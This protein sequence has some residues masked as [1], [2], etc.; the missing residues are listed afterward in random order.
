MDRRT[1]FRVSGAGAA[2]AVS[3]VAAIGCQRPP[4]PPS[5]F[6][7]Y[8]VSN[9]GDDQNSGTGQATPWRTIERVN[10]ALREGAM[11]DGA[12]VLFQRGG[13][14][15]GEIVARTDE[16][17]AI[18]E[19]RVLLSGYGDGPRPTI[20]AYK[21]L[22]SAEAW[23]EVQPD[24]WTV[25]LSDR[26]SYSGNIA[27]GDANVG[28][29]RVDGQIFGA[30]WSRVGELSE[31]W[32]FYNDD[33]NL[34]VRSAGAPSTLATDL[35]AAVNGILISGYSGLSVI[36]LELVGCGGH[37]Y[38]QTAASGTEVSDCLIH[39][40]G[41][42][43]LHAGDPTRY[44][45]GIELWM[46]SKDAV[47]ADN[48]IFDVYD[49]ATTVQ[50]WQE[51]DARLSITNCAFR[52]NLIWNCTQAFEFWAQGSQSRP[53]TGLVDCSFTDNVCVNAGRSWGYAARKDTKH[54]GNFVM[55]HSQDLSMGVSITGNIFFEAL[56][57][58]VFVSTNDYRFRPGIVFDH[59]VIA[60]R[61]NT[62]IQAELPFTIEQSAEW[63]TSTGQDRHSTWM[64]VPPS[65]ASPAD[66]LQYVRDNADVLRARR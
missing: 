58:Y 13:V 51:G 6:I 25:R 17:G 15:F 27:S 30:K 39:E 19:N 52:S 18:A 4:V 23:R 50:G 43:Q 34:Y 42:S 37:A 48:E 56:D 3:P 29:L 26:V 16:L 45:N 54:K 22:D 1:F 10:R 41:G 47:L 7:S 40:I 66:A 28:F 59:N 11:Q 36:G 46:G 60:L 21:I 38:Q 49:A 2:I 53:G 8:Y 55:V 44:G 62:P 12:E 9:T 35:R 57:C 32:D 31:Q 33:H 14:F 61:A 64:V 24:V 5:R 20:S 65:L 63:V